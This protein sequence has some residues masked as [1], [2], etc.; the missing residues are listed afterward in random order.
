MKY[1]LDTCVVSELAKPA[2]HPMV[3]DWVTSRDEGSFYL[4]VLSVGEIQKGIMKLEDGERRRALQNWLEVDLCNRFAGRILPVDVQVARAWGM[5]QA[6]SERR[7]APHPTI[8]G[9]LAATA[10]AHNLVLVTRNVRDFL[11]T[12]AEVFCPWPE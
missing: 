9:L 8:D 4:S 11:N 5:R 6:E 2:P 3:V 7:G 1:L 12:G 10:I